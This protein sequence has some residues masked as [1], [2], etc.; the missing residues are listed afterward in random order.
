MRQIAL[1][2]LGV[3]GVGQALAE[4]V[5]A[6]REHLAA[7]YGFELVYR[8]LADS[9]GA[10]VAPDAAQI[11]AALATRARG[12]KLTALSPVVDW[13]TLL[14]GA[15]AIVVDVSAAGGI[16]RDLVEAIDRGHRVVLAN[17]R[18]LTAAYVDFVALTRGGATRYEAT[19]GAGL[20]VLD[21]LQRLH[22]SGDQVLQIEASMSGTLGFLCSALEQG[23]SYTAAVRH[24]HQQ[25]WTEPDPRDDLSGADVARKALILA[26]SCGFSWEANAVQAI[27]L[28]PAAMAQLSR[29]AFMASLPQ[30]DTDYA[31]RVAEAAAQGQVLRYSARVSSKGATVTLTS[32]ET[33]H[34]LAHLRGTDNLFSFTTARYNERPLVVR[35]PGAG[36]DVTAAGVLGDIIATARTL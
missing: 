32:V 15:A 31:Q 18:P 13:Q 30:L 27:A 36:V 34:P 12:G 21:T 6:T 14:E 1:I 26:R 19:V 25:G 7:R 35:G 16:E 2:Q 8:G 33:A 23:M 29:D 20:P 17:K 4:Q 28:F 11:A 22:D 5:L 24:A 10:I 3:G 9:S